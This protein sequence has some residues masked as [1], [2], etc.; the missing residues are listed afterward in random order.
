MDDSN[1]SVSCG[2]EIILNF[3]VE[4]FYPLQVKKSII[5]QEIKE[6]VI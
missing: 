3:E 1:C 6:L 2:M 5:N 4:T